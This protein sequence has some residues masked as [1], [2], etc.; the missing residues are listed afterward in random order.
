MFPP[1]A[2]APDLR[3]PGPVHRTQHAHPKDA[4]LRAGHRS[5]PA[6]YRSPWGTR[7]GDRLP[8]ASSHAAHAEASRPPLPSL[9]TGPQSH[10]RIPQILAPHYLVLV[11]DELVYIFQIKLVR[12][13]A[14]APRPAAS[15]LPWPLQLQLPPAGNAFPP[16]QVPGRFSQQRRRRA[17]AAARGSN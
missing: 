7:R 12:H 11:R 9:G 8:W 10:A 3:G 5:S 6:S 2:P 1:P 4:D 13:G 17:T 16:S 15:E 14:A